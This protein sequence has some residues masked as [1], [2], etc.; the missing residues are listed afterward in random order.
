[1]L[2]RRSFV[3]VAGL[4]AAVVLVAGGCGGGGST[5]SPSAVNTTVTGSGT[6]TVSGNGST[7]APAGTVPPAGCTGVTSP[8]GAAKA[9]PVADA[10]AVRDTMLAIAR[11][12]PI[13]PG[14]AYTD[15]PIEEAWAKAYPNLK[16]ALFAD[17]EPTVSTFSVSSGF[18]TSRSASGTPHYNDRILGL[19]LKDSGGR[20]AGGVIVIPA[21]NGQIATGAP[22]VFQP[23]DMSGAPKCSA[24][25]AAD[26]YQP[27]AV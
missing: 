9:P 20:C 6:T 4:V 3:A 22:T 15:T 14:T 21:V 17:S 25:S 18:L 19:A 16:S 8:T 24:E 1:M 27:G 7:A 12:T 5:V 23:V 13:P 10:A 11:C 26:V 2:V